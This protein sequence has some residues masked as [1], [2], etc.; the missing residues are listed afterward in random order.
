MSR[1]SSRSGP[2]LDGSVGSIL[3]RPTRYR[4]LPQHGLEAVNGRLSLAL[5][6]ARISI[7][8]LTEV[9][10]VASTSVPVLTVTTLDLSCAEHQSI[11]L[12]SDELLAKAHSHGVIEI[13]ATMGGR[14]VPVC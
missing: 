4:H 13:A 14:R 11:Q 7:V 9:M 2:A 8:S 5:D 3:S 10:I 12:M 1:R 6:P